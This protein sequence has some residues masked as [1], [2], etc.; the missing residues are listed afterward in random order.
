MSERYDAGYTLVEMMIV[1][2]LLGILGAV[3]I[4]AYRGYVNSGK[5]AEAKAGL[6]NIALLEEQS[7]AQNRTYAA[8]A[9]AAALDAAIGFKADADTNYTWSV[10]A[11]ASGIATSFTATAD[12]S[13]KGLPV[14]TIDEA[15][16]KTRD[17]AVGW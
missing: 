11:G 13:A 16:A 3:A 7:F 5:E 10:V 8:G 4:P 15:N 12:G 14:F 2:A 6:S 1:V 17:G 9:T